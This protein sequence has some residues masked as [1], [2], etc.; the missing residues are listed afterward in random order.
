[1]LTQIMS[2]VFWLEPVSKAG[3]ARWPVPF[4]PSFAAFA[5]A[6]PGFET[7]YPNG[8]ERGIGEPRG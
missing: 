1:M 6:R 8:I 7:G 4:L 5:R 3:Q 2:E